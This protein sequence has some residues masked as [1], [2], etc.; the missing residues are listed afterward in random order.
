MP[1]LSPSLPRN[2]SRPGLT[3]IGCPQ[4]AQTPVP[5]SGSPLSVVLVKPVVPIRSMSFSSLAL[6]RLVRTAMRSDPRI[7]GSVGVVVFVVPPLGGNVLIALALGARGAERALE[8]R[9][10]W[11]G[12]L[13]H[14]VEPDVGG[15]FCRAGHSGRG[16][17][18][19]R[20]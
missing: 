10:F 13:R 8:A 17:D 18:L 4:L 9:L 7:A 16:L 11:R 14:D 5:V 12:R 20:R 1:S 2:C 19:R 15:A 3:P 6:S